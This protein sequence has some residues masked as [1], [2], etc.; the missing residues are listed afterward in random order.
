MA[1]PSKSSGDLPRL[2]TDAVKLPGYVFVRQTFREFVLAADFKIAH[3]ADVVSHAT[4]RF[5]TMILINSRMHRQIP[6]LLLLTSASRGL[7][8]HWRRWQFLTGTRFSTV[9]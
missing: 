4:L 2:S 7:Y 5:S 6:A 1:L 3:G 9:C 8:I